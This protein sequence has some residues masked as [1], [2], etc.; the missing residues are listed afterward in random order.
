[1][2]LYSCNYSKFCTTQKHF[3]EN[4][5]IFIPIH[6]IIS[7]EK[8]QGMKSNQTV[9]R[10]Q[11]N[12]VFLE[13]AKFTTLQMYSSLIFSD[14]DDRQILP[15][16]HYGVLNFRYRLLLITLPLQLAIVSV[17]VEA[18]ARATGFHS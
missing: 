10:I 8:H 3:F 4:C 18:E 15:T 7:Y 5:L 12:K 14:T 11:V 13:T 2:L 1:M 6:V 17:L 9:C 16:M